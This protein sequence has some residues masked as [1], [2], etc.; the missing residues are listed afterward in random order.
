[1]HIVASDEIVLQ[2]AGL[3]KDFGQSKGIFGV[4]LTLKAG[5]VVGFVGPN[6]AGKSTTINILAGLTRPDSGTTSAF[7][8]SYDYRTFYKRASRIGV[9][10]SEL[11]LDESLTAHKVFIQ[12]Q[13]LLGRDC[14]LQWQAMAE[15]L[16]L[17]VHKPIRKL[18]L[19]NKKK[20]GIVHALM[21]QPELIIMDE[22][23]S[24]LDPIIRERFVGIIKEAAD[25]GSSI[26][27][28][29]HDLGEVQEVSTQIVMIKEGR[30][31]LDSPTDTILNLAQRTFQLVAPPRALVQK[32]E[33]LAAVTDIRKNALLYTFQAKDYEAV[34][35][36]ITSEHFYNFYIE[37]PNLEDAFK[38]YYE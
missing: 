32:V 24:G 21:H 14:S 6:G 8:E 37:K 11:T 22:P 5:A 29:S 35:R 26:L 2:C 1:M 10:F 34:T 16:N 4:D 25:A 30:I 20:V 7:G 17:D 31:V 18:S 19:G 3:T 33:K 12:S 13:Q 9:M 27:L 38:D 36:L 23:T 15:Q 28:S